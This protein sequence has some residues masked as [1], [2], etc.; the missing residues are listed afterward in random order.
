MT[1]FPL[2]YSALKAAMPPGFE[3]AR[4]SVKVT[5]K[6]A[7]DVMKFTVEMLRAGAGFTAPPDDEPLPRE[8][9][10]HK[11]PRAVRV[12][13]PDGLRTKA[14][15]ASK[16]GCSI[17]TLDGHVASGALRYVALGHGKTRP[18][19]MFTDADLDAFITAQ[20]RKDVPCPPTAS[21]ARRSGTSIS[22][23]EVIGFTALLKRRRDVKRKK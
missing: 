15:A 20:T 12:R 19:R 21:G 5:D 13:P 17:K 18:R 23:S 3:N 9:A 6:N 8:R 14:E 2:Y 11:V 4:V 10:A 7:D 1:Q 16:L 22:G